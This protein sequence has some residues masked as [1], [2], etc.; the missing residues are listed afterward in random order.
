MLAGDKGRVAWQL[1]GNGCRAAAAPAEIAASFC[2]HDLQLKAGLIALVT[3]WGGLC[4]L[5][6]SRVLGEPGTGEW[7]H[8]TWRLLQSLMWQSCVATMSHVAGEDG[9]MSTAG[10]SASCRL[11]ESVEGAPGTG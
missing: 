9:A 10:L 2:V 1:A 8:T 5:G 6:R 4:S 11:A 7:G 3:P